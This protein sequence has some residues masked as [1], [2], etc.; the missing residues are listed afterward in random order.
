MKISVRHQMAIFSSSFSTLT[1][2]NVP[3]AVL[4]FLFA[5]GI[6]N[7]VAATFLHKICV[8]Y[9]HTSMIAQTAFQIGREIQVTSRQ[10]NLLLISVVPSFWFGIF[11]MFW[12]LRIQRSGR[13]S[14]RCIQ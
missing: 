5:N 14:P 7:V 3:K 9:E 8:I 4:F 2:A 6:I 10:Q 12:G 1:L 13:F 11:Y